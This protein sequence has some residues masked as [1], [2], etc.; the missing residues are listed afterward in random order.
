LRTNLHTPGA[1]VVIS[2]DKSFNAYLSYRAF[3]LASATDAWA[4]SSGLR[5][6]S[7]RSG[8]FLGSQ[9]ALR[10]RWQTTANLFFEGWVVY[11]KDGDYQDRV[12]NSPHVGSTIYSLLSA[13]ISF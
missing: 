6:P 2:P 4:G 9:W 13:T 3:F 1:R 8:T 5:D 11:R 10:A 12:A 7:G